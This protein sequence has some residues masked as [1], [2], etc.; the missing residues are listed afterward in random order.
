MC[1]LYVCFVCASCVRCVCVYRLNQ[2]RCVYSHRLPSLILVVLLFYPP[3]TPP[4][5]SLPPSLDVT[6]IPQGVAFATWQQCVRGFK[7]GEV[8]TAAVRQEEGRWASKVEGHAAEVDGV[9][10][11]ADE[12]LRGTAKNEWWWRVWCILALKEL[13]RSHAERVHVV[14]AL[15]VQS[16]RSA[17]QVDAVI[18]SR[19]LLEERLAMADAMLLE[20]ERDLAVGVTAFTEEW[21]AKE[22]SMLAAFS[23]T[24]MSAS[25]SSSSASSSSSSSALN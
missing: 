14:A 21:A 15:R 5:L 13:K 18:A 11:E 19:D 8:M 23:S 2:I 22:D 25:S 3:F 6:C 24:S 4:S 12:K 1:A 7:I 16:E 9:R 10:R 17:A 20:K